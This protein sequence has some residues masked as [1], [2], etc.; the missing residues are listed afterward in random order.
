MLSDRYN[1]KPI[2]QNEHLSAS[3]IVNGTPYGYVIT[4]P[5]MESAFREIMREIEQGD[6]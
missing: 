1:Q 6:S 3:D 4:E 2:K 5:E